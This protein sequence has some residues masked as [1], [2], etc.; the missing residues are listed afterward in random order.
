M[1]DTEKK[2]VIVLRRSRGKLQTDVQPI[3]LEYKELRKKQK[4]STE[5]DT[6]KQYTE[7]LEDLQRMEGDAIHMA[8]R[9][10]KVISKGLDT[11]DEERKRSAKEKKD[12]AIEDFVHNS[13]KAVS[14]SMKEASDIP[15]DIAE[16]LSASSYRK[17]LRKNLRRV[18]KVIRLF[19]I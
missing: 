3:V 9:S 15:M 7:G 19:R 16:A 4:N 18:S 8:R 17:Q 13:A 12:G 5:N 14:A 6:D 2:K 1:S 10:A 11:Y